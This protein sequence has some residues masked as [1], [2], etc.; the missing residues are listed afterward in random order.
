MVLPYNNNVPQGS[1]TIA[2]TQAPILQNTQSIDAAF[3]D[4]ANG[5]FTKYVF[6]NV[7]TPSGGAPADPISILHTIADTFGKPQLKFTNSNNSGQYTLGAT[8]GSIPLMGGIILKWGQSAGGAGSISVLFNP[9][10]GDFLNN[11]FAVLVT[12]RN[13]G[14]NTSGFNVNSISNTGF[15]YFGSSHGNI[16][17]FAIGN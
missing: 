7:G 13:S 17:W 8:T 12:G 11:C 16:Y 15:T 1:Q 10:P 4:T 6:Q 2:S 9:N 3:N 14:N 5:N